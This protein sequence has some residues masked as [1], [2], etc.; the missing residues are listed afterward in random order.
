MNDDIKSLIQYIFVP[1]PWNRKTLICKYTILYTYSV[2]IHFITTKQ[3]ISNFN[4]L[5]MGVLTGGEGEE[6]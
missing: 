1:I 3:M 6:A 4:R 5:F 2:G